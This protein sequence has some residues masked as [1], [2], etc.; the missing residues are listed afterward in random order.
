MHL[1]A[2][3]RALGNSR[4]LQTAFDEAREA[5]ERAYGLAEEA[6]APETLVDVLNGQATVHYYLG[7]VPAAEATFK[8][9]LQIADQWDLIEHRAVLL[10]NLGELAWSRKDSAEALDL[11][12]RAEA[13]SRFVGMEVG[14]ADGCRIQAE[15]QLSLGQ[16]H[17]AEEQALIAIEAAERMAAP[18][19]IA[20]AQRTLADVLERHR[21]IGGDKAL[22]TPRIRAAYVAASA[23][24]E[25][26]K[27][28]QEASECRELIAAL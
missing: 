25:A 6:N 1:S 12:E 5:F 24:Y 4:I 17:L 20:S 3:Y 2:A 15:I 8:K 19:Y 23:A 27:M 18:R 14:L 16:L 26:A 10:N 7:E 13:L 22:L 28:P 9:A 11:L 21:D